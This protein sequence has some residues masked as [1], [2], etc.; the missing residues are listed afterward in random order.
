MSFASGMIVGHLLAQSQTI[1]APNAILSDDDKGS[2]PYGGFV[3]G[4]DD[5]EKFTAAY[6]LVPG[7]TFKLAGK[8][9]RDKIYELLQ[10]QIHGIQFGIRKPNGKIESC[11]FLSY[12]TALNRVVRPE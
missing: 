7:N 5:R 2:L 3:H 11:L 4:K 9:N 12:A 6:G 1:H 10:Y 8:K